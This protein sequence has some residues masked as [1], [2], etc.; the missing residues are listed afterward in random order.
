MSLSSDKNYIEFH[1]SDG[2][3]YQEQGNYG[4]SSTEYIRLGFKEFKKVFDMSSFMKQ[5]TP[6]S[7]FKDNQKMMSAR[8]LDKRIGIFKNEL[9]SAGRVLSTR[10]IFNLPNTRIPDSIWKATAAGTQQPMIPDLSLIH[11]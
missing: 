8:Q 1:L 7:V 10:Y 2:S 11:I 9:D 5:T 3:R 4:D 6:D